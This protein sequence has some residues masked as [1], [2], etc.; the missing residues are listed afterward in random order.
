MKNSDSAKELA[1]SVKGDTRGTTEA[2]RSALEKLTTD[3]AKVTV[4]H[5]GV[6]DVTE[7]DVMLASASNGVIIAFKTSVP[8]SSRAVAPRVASIASAK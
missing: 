8:E 2:V 6:G 7:N 3:E 1:L 4:L 5:S